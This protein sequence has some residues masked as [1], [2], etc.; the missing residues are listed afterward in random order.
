VTNPAVPARS[1]QELLALAKAK[2]GELNFGSGGV[3]TTPHMAGE[4][5]ASIAG[6]TPERFSGYIRSEFTKWAQVI[7]DAGVKTE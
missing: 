4:L 7:K 2:P 3:G 5:F 6:S 1:V